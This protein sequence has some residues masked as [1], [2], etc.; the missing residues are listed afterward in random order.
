MACKRTGISS[1]LRSRK[2]KR[3]NLS[4]R[5]GKP[6]PEKGETSARERGNLSPRRFSETRINTGFARG[7]KF[8]YCSKLFLTV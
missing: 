6:Q 5:R 1:A 2:S 4:P 3:G 8:S 7:A